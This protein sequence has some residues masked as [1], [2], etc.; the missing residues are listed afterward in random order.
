MLQPGPSTI[1][2]NDLRNSPMPHIHGCCQLHKV[3]VGMTRPTSPGLWYLLPFALAIMWSRTD[4]WRLMQLSRVL[5]QTPAA[6]V[7]SNSLLKLW[8]KHSKH[9][10]HVH[11]SN[12]YTKPLVSLLVPPMKSIQFETVAECLQ[13]YHAG[14]SVGP[15]RLSESQI[16]HGQEMHRCYGGSNDVLL[17]RVLA[18]APGS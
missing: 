11:T 16:S 17:W 18:L 8:S 9:H 15:Q 13:R 10:K 14:R 5:L 7:S 6:Q 12:P 1:N 3:V 2:S 4:N